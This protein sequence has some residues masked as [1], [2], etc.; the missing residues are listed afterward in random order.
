VEDPKSIVLLIVEDDPEDEEFLRQAVGEIIESPEWPNWHT[1]ELIPA[2]TLG[3]A[4]EF[5]GQCQFDAILLNLSLPDGETLLAT[6]AKI[7]A[8]SAGLPILILAD[9][10][11]EDLAHT[12]L[13]HGAQ[14]VQ[15]K[16]QIECDALA[17]AIRY[18]IERRRRVHSLEA[19]SFFDELTSL[20]NRRGFASFAEHDL[21]LARRMGIPVLIAVV[22]LEGRGLDLADDLAFDMKMIRASELLLTACGEA[23]IVGRIGS[24]TFGICSTSM[25]EGGAEC[26]SQRFEH[27][28]ESLTIRVGTATWSEGHPGGL[29]DLLQEATSRLSP[30]A[31]ILAH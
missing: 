2:S 27:E 4:L 13:R 5:L 3:E 14:D 31:A 9:W 10:E 19:V 20:Y 22:E 26:F 16:S 1:C 17:R 25:T 7:Q 28:L 12:L 6:F 21:L 15:V 29:P 8:A 30:K 24:H 11:D 23:A 18:S